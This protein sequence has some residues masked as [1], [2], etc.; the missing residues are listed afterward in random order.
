MNKAVNTLS[1]IF[2]LLYGFLVMALGFDLSLSSGLSLTNMPWQKEIAYGFTLVI[3]LL[4]MLRIIRRWQGIKD[5]KK[6]DSFRYAQP[7]S[8]RILGL[9]SLFTM[10]ETVFMVGAI[11]FLSFLVGYEPTL[12]YPM[13]AVLFI[14]ALESASF[15]LRITRKG[16]AFR[17]GISDTA[18]AYF[19]R[20]MHILYFTSLIRV[21][22]H[23]D[24]INFQYKDDLNLFLPLD[25]IRKEDLAE[26]RRT[27]MDSLTEYGLK[28]SKTIYFDDA[29][30]N[31]E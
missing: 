4:G 30:R 24:M 13:I 18:V 10:A 6:F 25:V 3:F 5:M 14:L 22:M 20:E 27:L 26:F 12:V 29:F 8:H 17:I 16:K 11:I 21:E 31:L 23:Q 7:I 2:F 15:A 9:S 19:D 28:K 1:G